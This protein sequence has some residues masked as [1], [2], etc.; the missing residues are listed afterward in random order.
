MTEQA[1]RLRRNAVGVGAVTFF[2]VSA[3][4]PLVAI[5]GGFPIGMM[6][7]DGAGM[8]AALLACVAVLLLFAAGYTAMARH[9]VTA[10]G[11]YAFAA[12]GLGGIAGGAAAWI[13]V[14][15]YNAMQ[16]GIYGM[17][18]TAARA[19]LLQYL[20]VDLPW[21]DYAFAA[22][23]AVAILGYRQVDLS[24]KI[25]GVLVTAEYVAML[26]LDVA[27]LR[28]GGA[29]GIT[30]VSFTPAAALSGS[31]AI[32][33]LFCFAGFMGFE[34]TTI[35][36]EE[37]RDPERTIPRATY[38]SVL[39]IGGFYAFS[40]W[41]LVIGAGVGTIVGE[42]RSLADPTRFVF[43]TAVRYVG[44]WLSA[45]M[46]VLFV[47]SVFAGLLAFHNAAA[48]YF[49]AL[50]RDGL[51]PRSLGRTHP[52]YASPNAGSATQTAIAA[53]VVALFALLK[54]DPVLTLFSWLTNVGTL[55][56]I[57]LMALSSAAV[58]VFFARAG[59]MLDQGVFRTRIAPVVAG[60]ALSV[61]L[62]LAVV[63]FDVL[64]GSFGALRIVLPALVFVAGALGAW[65]AWA[66]RRRDPA[67]YARLG[68]GVALE[69]GPAALDPP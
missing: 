32:A 23:V 58:P 9:V 53:A 45:T 65:R 37:A 43:D 3:A 69:T 4:G 19:L 49:Y 50:G 15:A 66:M 34:A 60:L 51:L 28:A 5:A 46:S 63:H 41:C 38:L 59:G 12:R 17:F 55:G 18:G 20:H 40:L 6:F 26:I 39:L 30:L 14:V 42:L 33:I 21:Y 8:P 29:H 1:N 10:G 7:G 36:G 52:R 68:H 2:V 16:I 62:V 54:L 11:F 67:R 56:V 25:L 13:A 61:V 24:A 22:V 27:I 64:T 57:A 31:P 44:P 48:R 35:Y 47:T